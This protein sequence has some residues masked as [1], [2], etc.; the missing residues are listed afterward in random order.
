MFEFLVK[1]GIIFY[2]NVKENTAL[3]KNHVCKKYYA[4]PVDFSHNGEYF[5]DLRYQQFYDN[6]GYFYNL[7]HFDSNRRDKYI[8]RQSGIELSDGKKAYKEKYSPSWYSMKY[9]W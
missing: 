4:I 3:F 5:G 6:I 1:D 2:P 7:D 9:L 8:K